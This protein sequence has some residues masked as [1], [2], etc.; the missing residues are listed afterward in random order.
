MEYPIITNCD[1]FIHAQPCV[2]QVALVALLRRVDGEGRRLYVH[3][4]RRQ[5][6]ALGRV[7]GGLGALARG[8]LLPAPRFQR[9]LLRRHVF[10]CGFV[11]FA[12]LRVLGHE[13]TLCSATRLLF[14][15]LLFDER[16]ALAGLARRLLGLLLLFFGH[17][18]FPIE[19]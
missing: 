3:V 10:R 15:L 14:Y 18:T 11:R 16:G 5:L 2:L 13:H 1:A 7:L 19:I 8:L 4:R 12:L 9:E 17:C 6:A